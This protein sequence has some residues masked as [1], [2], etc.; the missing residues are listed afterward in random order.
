MAGKP[1]LAKTPFSFLDS[2]LQYPTTSGNDAALSFLLARLRRA[3]P[4]QAGLFAE[5][6]FV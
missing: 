5:R 2:L 4:S 6:S 3:S 1:L